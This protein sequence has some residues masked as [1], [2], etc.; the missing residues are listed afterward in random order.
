MSDVC[1]W[2][3][4]PEGVF[5]Y[6]NSWI[7]SC[8]DEFILTEDTPVGNGMKY[9]CYCGKELREVGDEQL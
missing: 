6:E 2:V 1:E 9:C 3:K 7:T 4:E 5:T 8:G